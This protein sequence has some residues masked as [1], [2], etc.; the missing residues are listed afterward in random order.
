DEHVLL[1]EE[2]ALPPVVS[3]TTESLEYLAESDPEEDIEEYENALMKDGPVDYPMD[4]GDDGD[5]DDGE[6]RG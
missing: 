3:P 1:N 5:D 4:E 2:H 6:G